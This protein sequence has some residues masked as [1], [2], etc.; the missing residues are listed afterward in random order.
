MDKIK[1]NPQIHNRQ[2]IRLKGYDYSQAGLYFVTL[3]VNSKKMLFGNIEKNKND[4]I[5][6]ELII[7]E[8]GEMLKEEWLKITQ[9]FNNIRLHEFIVMPNH[10]HAI[11]E[12]ENQIAKKKLGDV[13]GAYKSI[14]TVE[15]IR[16]V[17]KKNWQPFDGRLWQRNYWEHIIRNQKSHEQIANYIHDNPQKWDKD[18]FNIL[19]M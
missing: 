13:I 18:L 8:V 11:L 14:T 5:Y 15:Y 2:S 9:R 16:N 4:V 17:K 7:N 3:V 6:N 1:Y 19:E 10:F 12:I